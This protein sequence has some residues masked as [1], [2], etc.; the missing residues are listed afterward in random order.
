[1][2][3]YQLSES[4]ISYDKIT[5]AAVIAVIDNVYK[6]KLRVRIYCGNPLTGKAWTEEN[7]VIG[8]I[9][10][11]TG[12]VKIPLLIANSRSNGG[13]GLLDG[14]ILKIT[15]AKSGNVLYQH[16]TFHMPTF[17]KVPGNAEGLP[18]GIK[19]DGKQYSNHKTEKSRDKLYNFFTK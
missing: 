3:E 8:T 16:P 1:M 5:P 17:E 13:H 10:R 19:V 4:G 6:S 2:K 12:Q 11:S 18:Y 7:D 15:D 14:C 9:G